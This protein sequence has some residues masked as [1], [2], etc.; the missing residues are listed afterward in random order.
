MPKNIRSMVADSLTRAL[1]RIDGKLESGLVPPLPRIP[2]GTTSSLLTSTATSSARRDLASTMLSWRL[3]EEGALLRAE[4]PETSRSID[5]MS[6]GMNAE[7]VSPLT[8]IL[9]PLNLANSIC[10]DMVG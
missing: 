6:L 4:N 3:E 8:L 9:L 5:T 7:I 10:A 1:N 2:Q